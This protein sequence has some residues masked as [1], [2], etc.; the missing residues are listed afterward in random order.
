[1]LGTRAGTPNFFSFASTYGLESWGSLYDLAS[2]AVSDLASPLL[3][4]HTA[5]HDDVLL[6]DAWTDGT[7]HA[8]VA[9][10]YYDYN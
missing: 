10:L 6:S 3:A 1:M 7:S 5:A 4:H 9:V 8:L 2:R